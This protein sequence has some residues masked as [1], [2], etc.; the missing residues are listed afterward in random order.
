MI[1]MMQKNTTRPAKR[2]GRMMPSVE[3]IMPYNLKAFFA[4][5]RMPI[6][7]RKTLHIINITARITMLVPGRKQQGLRLEVCL[8][9]VCGRACDGIEQKVGPDPADSAD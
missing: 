2:H 1:S 6:L 7:Q 3:G 9:S 8:H 4:Y 5:N